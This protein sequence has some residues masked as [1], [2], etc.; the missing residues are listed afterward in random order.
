M[1]IVYFMVPS[2]EQN[3]DRIQ[4]GITQ[5]SQSNQSLFGQFIP[6]GRRDLKVQIVIY[7]TMQRDPSRVLL[8]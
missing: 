8:V 7:F 6:E 4:S 2:T 5:F 3:E 1:P